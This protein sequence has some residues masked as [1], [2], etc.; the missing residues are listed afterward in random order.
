[1]PLLSLESGL[2]LRRGAKTI[3][4]V[5]ILDRTRVQFEDQLTKQVQTWTFSRLHQALQA[6]QLMPVLADEPLAGDVSAKPPKTVFITDLASLEDKYHRQLKRRML[7]VRSMRR[8]G[9]TRGQCEEIAR[10]I[11][12]V[13]T[14]SK[15]PAPPSASS[16]MDWMRD[17]ENSGNNPASLIS[18]NRCRRRRRRILPLVDELIT[19]F[20]KTVY[21]TKGRP[22]LQHTLDRINAEIRK[23]RDAGKLTVENGDAS[24][25]TLQRRLKDIDPF[26][27][28][29]AR[30]GE[31]YAR[32]K[33]RTSFEGTTA[34]RPLERVECDHTLLNWVV[35][36]D[37]TGLPL[38][39][40]TLTVVIDS[41]SGYVIGLYVSFYG[42]GLASVLNVLKNAICPK[43]DYARAAGTKKPWLAFGVGE[44]LLLD[45][46]MEFHSKDFL[47]A[48]WELGID[49]EYCRVRTPWLK[50]K[51]ERF[52]LNLDFLALSKGR[53]WKPEPNADRIDPKKDASIAFSDFL[54]GLIMFVVDVYPF[55][56]NSRT[57]T[58]PFDRY[59]EGLE[60]MPPP[61]L[62]SSLETL[63]LIAAKRASRMVGPGGVDILGLSYSSHE[64]LALKKAVGS[65]FRTDVKWN[66]DNVSYLYV[67]NPKNGSWLPVPSLNP[68]YTSGLSWLQHRLIRDHSRKVRKEK[69]HGEHLMRAKEDLHDLWMNSLGKANKHV[70]ARKL[71]QYA[72]MSSA[73][74]VRSDTDKEPPPARKVRSPE[75]IEVQ[76]ADVP[77]YESFVM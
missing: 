4:F 72:G 25:S 77:E 73:S 37:R 9:I 15:D 2:V 31:T 11:D 44:T 56:E 60:D 22:T 6:K 40:P 63:D 45:N 21:L 19:R 20:I 32:S 51:V 61:M 48:S 58:T 76:Y 70:D 17:Y 47:A 3:E 8:K 16:V 18:G 7:Y 26:T 57:L 41:Y 43:D 74:F 14:R 33:F 1:M 65:S 50:P 38:G 66:L 28:I 23:L 54:R 59:Q 12:H 13:A 68:E 69:G 49:V 62:A 29:K 34:T 67:Q 52:F 10:H 46:G 36:C 24:L 5:R 55:E 64:L 35:V 30:F 53:V 71:A 27:V 42:P 39:R 75:E